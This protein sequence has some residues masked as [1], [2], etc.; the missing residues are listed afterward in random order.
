LAARG[1]PKSAFV[2]RLTG[3]PLPFVPTLLVQED[4][5][6]QEGLGRNEHHSC[7]P[8]KALMSGPLAFQAMRACRIERVRVPDHRD[9]HRGGWGI[10]PDLPDSDSRQFI[11]VGLA[12]ALYIP[13]RGMDFKRDCRD[14]RI[15][16]ATPIHLGQRRYAWRRHSI[17]PESP[18]IVNR[19]LATAAIERAFAGK[20][21][22]ADKRLMTGYLENP[23]LYGLGLLR[24]TV[25]VAVGQTGMAEVYAKA[26]R[27]QFLPPTTPVTAEAF[28]MTQLTQPSR[29]ASSGTSA[30]DRVV[31]Y[32]VAA[33]LQTACLRT[34]GERVR[35][36][37][38]AGTAVVS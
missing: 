7:H 1:T 13:G 6:A 35:S 36:G 37:E 31:A 30:S 20:P 18:D 8:R 16:Y 14:R 22:G 32:P 27:G 5:A 15:V 33:L 29:A 17:R 10:V 12:A 9:A 19:Y 24:R 11:L 26:R 2:D 3:V 23:E 4:R 28:L 34:V 25:R 38:P 21:A